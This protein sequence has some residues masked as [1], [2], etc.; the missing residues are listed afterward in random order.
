MNLIR[1][2][3]GSYC[4]S[5]AGNLIRNLNGAWLW[6][7]LGGNG[8]ETCHQPCWEPHIRNSYREPYRQP[9]WNA[10]GVLQRLCWEP[11]SSKWGTIFVGNPIENSIKKQL[12]GHIRN[13]VGNHMGNPAV[14]NS[15]SGN[16]L[17]TSRNLSEAFNF[18]PE[19]YMCWEPHSKLCQESPT[20]NPVD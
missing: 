18:N 12:V 3:V 7:P 15:L 4:G 6:S 20:W 19:P 9:C 2:P 10:I 5:V 8:L 13:I 14:A 1:N 17:K 11:N 16:L